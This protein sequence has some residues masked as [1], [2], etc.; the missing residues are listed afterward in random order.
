MKP[1]PPFILINKDGAALA[2]FKTINRAA[3]WDYQRQRVYVRSSKVIKKACQKTLQRKAKRHHVKHMLVYSNPI[4]CRYCGGSALFKGGTTDVFS[5]DI[6]FTH[7]GVK[8]SVT[9][10]ICA[11][12][13][14]VRCERL[15][16]P[17][18][19]DKFAFRKYGL[20][21]RAFAAYQL[22]QL[23]ISEITVAKSL[24]EQLA[25]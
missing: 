3:Y 15:V 21:L 20:H 6:R 25:G 1:L 12:W 7:S 16:R 4:S 19:S 11:N 14:C 2:E 13:Y 24:V 17:P 8:G 18:A 23:R 5:H 10:H 22:I 9:R